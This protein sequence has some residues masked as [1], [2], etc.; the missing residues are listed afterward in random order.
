MARGVGVA[1][2]ALARA[3]DIK[4]DQVNAAMEELEID[5]AKLNPM[6]S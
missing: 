6:I 4:L 1:A 3:G 5:P 2:D